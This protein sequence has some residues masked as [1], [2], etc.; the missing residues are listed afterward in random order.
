MAGSI[1]DLNSGGCAMRYIKQS[2]CLMVAY[3]TNNENSICTLNKY[4]SNKDVKNILQVAE[5]Y[6]IPMTLIG[7]KFDLIYEHPHMIS[8]NLENVL[9]FSKSWNMRSAMI[10]SSLLGANVQNAVTTA[11]EYALQYQILNK[12]CLSKIEMFSSYQLQKTWKRER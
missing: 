12:S 4:Y 5:N 2:D 8:Q 7:M 6:G 11:I 1:Q 10:T 3:D 9:S